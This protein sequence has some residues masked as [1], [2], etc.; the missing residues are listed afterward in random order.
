M[1]DR[2]RFL[3]LAGS[4]SLLTTAQGPLAWA[5]PVGSVRS[6]RFLYVGTHDAIQVYALSA[7]KRLLP[8]QT[9]PAARPVAL[10][11]YEGKLY[12]ANG[13][14]QVENLPRGS[15][16]AYA[17]DRVTGR[18]QRM[19]RVALSLSGTD[20][21]DLA[22]S[23]DGRSLVV[24]IHGGGAYNVV[25]LE[26]SGRLGRVTWIHKEIGSGPHTL[27]TS[28]HPAAVTMDR[29]GRILTADMG[30]DTLN[31]F[32]I[33]DGELSVAR[34]H[35]VQSGSGPASMVLDPGGRGLYVAHALDGTL[36]RFAYENGVLRG[37]QTIKCSAAGETAALA[38]HPSGNAL[39]SSHG[40][41]L[42]AWNVGSGGLQPLQMLRG[43]HAHAI[44]AT[45][46]GGT[47]F[48]ATKDAVLSMDIENLILSAPVQTVS[49]SRPLSLASL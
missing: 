23:P 16:E 39:Y 32:H 12:V 42:Q 31:V 3:Q 1:L 10:E 24:A 35:R 47:L 37:Q 7:R 14:S 21:R 40:R 22:V 6:A 19:N 34:R 41:G 46:D 44:E 27:Q 49:V 4:A 26:E 36:S 11:I 25:S 43:I 20:P 5:G 15:V 33:A 18:L 48:A 9:V 38:I 30:S 28:S 13:V 29:Q 2:R 45:A 8:L 17:I